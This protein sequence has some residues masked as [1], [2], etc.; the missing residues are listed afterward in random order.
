M[1]S[2][3]SARPQSADTEKAAMFTIYFVNN[4]KQKWISVIEISKCWN[5][6]QKLQSFTEKKI[7]FKFQ[8]PVYCYL[9][10]F[11]LRINVSS[12]MSHVNSSN[13]HLMYSQQELAK[14][15]RWAAVHHG[16]RDEDGSSSPRC[17]EENN[18][19]VL[20]ICH[21]PTAIRRTSCWIQFSAPWTNVINTAKTK[22]Y[23]QA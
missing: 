7:P 4:E 19:V 9:L 13:A 10:V 12:S 14:L 23:S 15:V 21:V 11:T 1:S 17:E 2:E 8:S 6:R 18:P 3:K 16:A 5:R 22:I 20:M